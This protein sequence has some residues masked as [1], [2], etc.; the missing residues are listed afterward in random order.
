LEGTWPEPEHTGTGFPGD[1]YINYH[2]YR[3]IFPTMALA[4]DAELRAKNS[5]AALDVELEAQRVKA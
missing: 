1:F 5:R 4:A 2:M 3:H